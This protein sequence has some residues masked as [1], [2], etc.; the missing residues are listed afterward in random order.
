MNATGQYAYHTTLVKVV[1]VWDARFT[2][3]HA[4]KSVGPKVQDRISFSQ[5]EMFSI[6]SS[7]LSLHEAKYACMTNYAPNRPT[8]TIQK[9]SQSTHKIGKAHP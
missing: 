8:A 1:T 6:L 9:L 2:P 3:T 4:I 5:V 7:R